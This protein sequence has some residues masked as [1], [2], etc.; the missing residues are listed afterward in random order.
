MELS[1][2]HGG[3]GGVR[4]TP[5]VTGRLC[6]I[7]AKVSRVAEHG[8]DPTAGRVLLADEALRVDLQGAT[9]RWRRSGEST[10]DRERPDIRRR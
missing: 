4:L 8:V 7:R 2:D 1:N 3:S 5:A 6:Q 10:L 9:F